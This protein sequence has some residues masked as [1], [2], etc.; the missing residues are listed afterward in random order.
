MIVRT[1]DTFLAD[2]WIRTGD[3]LVRQESGDLFV[4]DRVK[5]CITVTFTNLSLDTL[6]VDRN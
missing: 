2:G 6:H 1:R 4:V 5:V 3:Q